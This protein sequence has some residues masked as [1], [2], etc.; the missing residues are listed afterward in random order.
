VFSGEEGSLFHSTHAYIHACNCVTLK[1]RNLPWEANGGNI[2]IKSHTSA[3]GLLNVDAFL[4]VCMFLFENGVRE[5]RNKRYTT[6]S[7]NI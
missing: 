5:Y 1:T 4:Y 3:V 2:L 7:L 6:R